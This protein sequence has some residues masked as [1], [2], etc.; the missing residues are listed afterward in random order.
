MKAS[1]EQVENAI[2]FFAKTFGQERNY[3]SLMEAYSGTP[4]IVEMIVYE[5]FLQK[6]N[7]YHCTDEQ[8]EQYKIIHE[9]ATELKQ[10]GWVTLEQK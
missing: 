3:K 2:L 9:Y 5:M 7:S 8:Y 1:K 6:F 10:N 4:K